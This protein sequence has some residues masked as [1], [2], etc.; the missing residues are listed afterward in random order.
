[1][2]RVAGPGPPVVLGRAG[3]VSPAVAVSP[4]GDAV[5]AWVQSRRNRNRV[6]V[7]RRRQG[8]AFGA[9]EPLTPWRR[10][11]DFDAFGSSARIAA[12]M[13]AGGVATIAWAL[14]RAVPARFPD[15][16]TVGTAHAPAGGRFTH[17]ALAPAAQAVTR[18]ALAVAP[19]GWSLLAY[20]ES[21]GVRVLERAPGAQ[22]FTETFRAE[23]DPA[24]AMPAVAIRD[25]GGALVA[26]R[27]STSEADA[28]VIATTRAA[29]GA[30]AAPQT[31]VPDTS[32]SSFGVGVLYADAGGPPSDD[33][34]GALRAA[35][36]ADGRALLGWVS[37]RHGV[38][39][40]SFAPGTLAAG[41]AEPTLLGGPLR[42]ANGLAPL[43]LTDGRAAVA[44]TDNATSLGSPVGQG[45][46]HVAAESA[47]V[48]PEPAPPR[49]TVTA[50]RRQRLYDSQPL[51][52]RVG[53]DRPCDL[54]VTLSQVGED[55]A[56][57]RSLAVARTISVKLLH[58][59]DA[60]RRAA[61]R[62]WRV[63]VRATAPNGR[64]IVT[65]TRTVV[66]LRRAPLPVPRILNL[67]AAR[68]GGTIVVRWRT[69]FPARR[70]V[71]VVIGQRERGLVPD[72]F[73]QPPT[74]AV[75]RGRG[76]TR[77]RARLRSERPARIRWVGVYAYSLDAARGHRAAV[78]VRQ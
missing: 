32:D 52:A 58:L 76:R 56:Q 75:R 15:A 39:R 25:G 44:W 55:G 11:G 77:F 69:E 10:S 53:C 23:P 43:F 72:T 31:I 60:P 33:G 62:R 24:A 61:R 34:N 51:R 71:L 74:F 26:W 65:E 29:A 42:A 5:V 73:T 9:I 3:F 20:D 16:A 37:V 22:Q 19:D 14:P 66:I 40:A 78:R 46:L 28:G 12:A 50:P 59:D 70:A 68:R 17:Q 2:L 64:E 47:P 41:F 38:A 6:A 57:A 7:A 1:E 35:L 18:V 27:T 45:R 36:A 4:A 54:R 30:F 21:D 8:G 48:L 67:R 13:S 49:I 63:R